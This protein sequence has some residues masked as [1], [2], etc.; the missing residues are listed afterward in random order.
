M[1]I[2]EREMMKNNL[3]GVCGFDCSPICS[4]VVHFGHWEYIVC[5]FIEESRIWQK[6]SNNSF[7]P[8]DRRILRLAPEIKRTYLCRYIVVV[9]LYDY[10]ITQRI[11]SS[12][13]F[14]SHLPIDWERKCAEIHRRNAALY[15]IGGNI[16]HS[17]MFVLLTPKQIKVGR[18]QHL[19]NEKKIN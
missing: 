12:R 16:C 2:T 3:L 1:T 13:I 6:W 11:D 15:S 10:V 4:D 5:R 7:N 14:I 8:F 9:L 19:F 17:P 18:R